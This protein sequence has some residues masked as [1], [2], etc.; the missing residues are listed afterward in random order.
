MTDIKQ[1]GGGGSRIKQ[2][3]GRSSKAKQQDQAGDA[4]EV[5]ADEQL[6][7]VSGAAYGGVYRC[8]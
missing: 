7:P 5:I 2:Q 8:R 6:D 4:P 3:G 1:Q